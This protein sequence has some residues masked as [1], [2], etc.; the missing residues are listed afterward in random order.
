MIIL[1]SRQEQQDNSRRCSGRQRDK[2]EKGPR[3]HGADTGKQKSDPNHEYADPSQRAIRR[4]I[5][6]T[7]PVAVIMDDQLHFLFFPDRP[8]KPDKNKAQTYEQGA[9]RNKPDEI[10]HFFRIPCM[11]VLS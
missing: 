9:D 4:L 10:V 3:K 11:R 8:A 1:D 7:D 5:L 2:D 6:F